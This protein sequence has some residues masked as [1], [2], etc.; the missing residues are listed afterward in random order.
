MTAKPQGQAPHS[1]EAKRGWRNALRTGL[2]H[3][4]RTSNGK[5]HQPLVT[6]H[7]DRLTRRLVSTMKLKTLNHRAAQRCG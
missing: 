4:E 3:G 6:R 5:V 7:V 2:P 1:V